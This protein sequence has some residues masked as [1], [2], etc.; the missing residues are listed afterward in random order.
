ME[1]GRV[2]HPAPTLRR[3]ESY[4]HLAQTPIPPR[5]L[6]GRLDLQSFPPPFRLAPIRINIVNLKTG[7]WVKPLCFHRRVAHAALRKPFAGRFADRLALQSDLVFDRQTRGVVAESPRSR[8]DSAAESLRQ[9]LFFV[10]Q[11]RGV[12]TPP[13]SHRAIFVA[14]HVG[15]NF[16]NGGEWFLEILY[17]CQ[18]R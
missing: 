10:G 15:I 6:T 7:C 16:C 13:R 12:A 17:D 4:A 14:C 5:I 18:D 8:R 1:K 11:N 3:Y 9:S 2:Q